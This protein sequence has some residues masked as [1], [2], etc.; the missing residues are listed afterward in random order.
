MAVGINAP[1]FTIASGQSLSAAVR[2]N[3]TSAQMLLMPSGWD[4]ADISFAVCETEAGTYADLY[5]AFGNEIAITVAAGRAVLLPPGLVRAGT[6]LK[7]RSGTSGA[8]VAQ[9]ADRLLTLLTSR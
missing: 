5:D 7:L 9:T 8:P 2:L 6:W 3:G 4:A 1:T